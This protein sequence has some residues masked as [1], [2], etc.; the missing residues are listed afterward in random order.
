MEKS[1]SE[2]LVSSAGAGTGA[3]ASSGAVCSCSS[4]CG[5]RGGRRRLLVEEAAVD[6]DVVTMCSLLR[7]SSSSLPRPPGCTGVSRRCF[8]TRET[9]SKVT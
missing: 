8:G 9:P 1:K 4:E 2:V 3:R 6:L 7:I 5:G